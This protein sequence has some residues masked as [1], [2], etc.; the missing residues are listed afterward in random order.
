MENSSDLCFLGVGEAKCGRGLAESPGCH[1]ANLV[2]LIDL[3]FYIQRRVQGANCIVYKGF[4]VNLN[5][6]VKEPGSSNLKPPLMQCDILI[7]MYF[8]VQPLSDLYKYQSF[9]FYC[10]S[11]LLKQEF[12]KNICFKLPLKECVLKMWPGNSIRQAF[13]C[14]IAG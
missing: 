4:K 7:E 11:L 13:L 5:A 9:W 12:I 6:A 1:L 10:Q 8:P 2:N 3:K 14:E